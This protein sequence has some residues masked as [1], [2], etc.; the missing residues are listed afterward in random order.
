MGQAREVEV[1]TS[2]TRGQ[3][4]RLVEHRYAP[5]PD[6]IWIWTEA[7]L[8]IYPRGP[9]RLAYLVSRQGGEF[10]L[11][12]EFAIDAVTGEAPEWTLTLSAAAPSD[13]IVGQKIND[14]TTDF[15]VRSV[16]GVTVV[17]RRVAFNTVI[18]PVT[19]SPTPLR[20]YVKVSTARP[21]S[22]GGRIG[23]L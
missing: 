9:G 3:A 6:P 22:G 23:S 1:E 20:V 11:P 14:G 7:Q 5:N 16:S 13:L 4:I 8:V 17:V 12:W 15:L 18:D 19:G 21:A 2:L 10:T